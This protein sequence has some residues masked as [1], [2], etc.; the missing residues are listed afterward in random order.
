LLA[1][2]FPLLAILVRSRTGAKLLGRWTLWI[3]TAMIGLLLPLLLVTGSR[4]GVLAAGITGILSIVLYLTSGEEKPTQA[5][6]LTTRRMQIVAGIATGGLISVTIALSRAEAV[7]RLFAQDSADDLRFQVWPLIARMAQVYLPWGTGA[8]SFVE[9][10]RIGEPDRLLEPSYLNHAHN[11]FLEVFLTTGIPGL[12]L[13]ATGLLLFAWD[14]WRAWRAIGRSESVLFGRGATV[15]IAALVISSITD[16]PLRTPSLACFFV[17]AWLWLHA[18]SRDELRA[19]QGIDP[20][21]S[22]G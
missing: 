10:F 6:V 5:T 15:V 14:A 17:I 4:T 2:T 18:S 19:P 20:N 12:L 22:G 7:R 1:T 13:V 8:G 21:V 16:Y 3:A 11:D 9:I